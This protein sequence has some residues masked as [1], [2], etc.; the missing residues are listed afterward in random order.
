MPALASPLELTA[1]PLDV[2]VDTEE[3][4]RGTAT[5]PRRP[6]AATW[7]EESEP[8]PSGLGTPSRPP[9]T[10]TP[11]A[12]RPWSDFFHFPAGT[13]F[14]VDGPLSYN[15][16][17]KVLELTADSLKFELHMPDYEILG[18]KIP[19]AD[20]I[21]AVTYVQEGP[22]NTATIE[23]NGQTVQDSNLTIRTVG[24][25]RQIVPSVSIPGVNLT[26]ISVARDGANEID[27]D[28]TI[29]GQEWDFDLER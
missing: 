24:D 12:R 19:K 5:P 27:L 22:N 29:N 17:G 25:R 8:R 26:Q 18:Q 7:L 9:S 15:G 28:L 14:E 16:N 13:T 11:P 23:A 20:V 6:A 2:I 4:T 21:I 1:D 3:L 10:P